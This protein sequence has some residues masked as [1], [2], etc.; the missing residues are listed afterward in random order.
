MEITISS[1]YHDRSVITDR[2]IHN[3]SPDRVIFDKTIKEAHSIDAAIP[4]R[5][6]HHS[7]VN[8]K[9]QK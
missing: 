9:L 3:N 8:E 6:S 1:L 4:N 2:T 7:T 5:H